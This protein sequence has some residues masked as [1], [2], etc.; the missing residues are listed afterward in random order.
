MPAPAFLGPAFL[1]V[2]QSIGG[3]RWQSWE[4]DARLALAHAQRLQV[5]DLVGRLLA[6]RGVGLEEAERFLAPSLRAYLPDPSVLRDMDKA[7][8]RVA[9]CLIEGERAAVFGDYD[10]DGATS[11]ALLIRFFRAMGRDLRLYVPDR[12]KEGY[13]PNLA[14]MRTLREEGVA[15]VITVDCGIV[16]FE[17]LQG[18]AEIGLDV[19]VADHHKAEPQ[20]PAAHAV[21][22]PNRVDEPAGGPLS[23][24]A[25]VGVTF[26]LLVAVNRLLRQRGFYGDHRPE[27]DLMALLDLVA[28]GTICDVV[29]LTGLNRAFAA[30]G[31]RMMARR[32]N[33][34][35]VALADIAGVS[36]PLGAY[37]AGFI[38]GPRVNAGGRVGRADL[39]ARILS[40]D[41]P[42]AATALARELHALNAER[43]EIEAR[44]LQEV[45]AGLEKRHDQDAETA[46][47]IIAA[48]DGWHPGV[49]GIVAA[50]LKERFNRPACVIAFD[51][52][53]GKASGR[54]VRGVDLGAAVIAAR[55]ARLL[56]TGGGHAMAAGF[57]ILRERLQEAE[58]FLAA[59]ISHQWGAQGGH[60]Q[61]SLSLDGVLSVRGAS[62][63]LLEHLDRLAPYGA[64]NP[65]PRFALSDA[66]IV[67]ADIV[68]ERHV[69]CIIAG[70][71]GAR[72]KGIAF[73][74]IDQELGPGLLRNVGTP[75]Y[76]A[77]TLRV[78]RWNGQKAVQIFIDDAA[79]PP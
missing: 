69:R 44:T 33:P 48:G 7:A 59:H 3:R 22:N 8:A 32:A 36:E 18:A 61:A 38:V 73:R 17:A 15:L 49:I 19:V 46:P 58:A 42:H 71:D 72:L 74:A 40:T 55:Q 51:G 10:V 20:L 37:H 5:P 31:L 64:G 29:P 47:L 13:G 24:L 67:K 53:L 41:D 16:S 52:D 60:P 26:L 76:L 75:L 56:T 63:E 45:L 2:E 30:Q 66:R 11:S 4:G 78:D 70:Q 65:E 28:L 68:G 25:A 39:G 57:S 6:Y 77:G 43:Q 23:H 50:R 35:L 12:L 54:S 62:L 79:L 27:P 21:V 14:A 9:H 1:G 34:G